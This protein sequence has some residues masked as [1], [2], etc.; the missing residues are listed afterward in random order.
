MKRIIMMLTVALVM[1]VMMVASGLPAFAQGQGPTTAYEHAEPSGPPG[2][3]PPLAF[4][5]TK[6]AAGF[7]A[8]KGLEVGP[9]S[10]YECP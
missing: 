4:G 1:A 9:G 10:P 6:P 8:C 7:N 5:G 2:P 3:S